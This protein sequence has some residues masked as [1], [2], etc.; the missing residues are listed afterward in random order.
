[1]LIT[2]IYI[3]KDRLYLLYSGDDAVALLDEKAIAESGIIVGYNITEEALNNLIYQTDMRRA[4]SKALDLLSRRDYCCVELKQRLLKIFSDDIC[5]A[6]I[7]AMLEK[8]YVNDERYAK[9]TAYSLLSYKNFS[10]SRAVFE[11][12]S[13]GVDRDIAQTAVD[14]NIDEME[15]DPIK[16]IYSVIVKKYP[17][18]HSDEKIK[19]R[20]FN[21]LMRLGYSRSDII[22]A[23]DEYRTDN[24][25][26]EQF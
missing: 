22:S 2:G 10:P 26:E 1:M 23:M 6:V 16:E 25:N 9:N 7:N 14:I 17:K 4:T 11:L 20:C 21:A 18:C 8:N 13:R 5:E 19:R 12:V 3:R 24:I 15:Y